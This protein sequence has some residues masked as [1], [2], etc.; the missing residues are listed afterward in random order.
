ME[1]G[2]FYLEDRSLMDELIKDKEW[3]EKVSHQRNQRKYSRKDSSV[4]LT[5]KWK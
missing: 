2:V 1:L 4:M 3:T 5:W